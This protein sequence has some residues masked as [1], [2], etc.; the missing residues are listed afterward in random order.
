MIKHSACARGK[1]VLVILRDGKRLEGRFLERHGGFIWLEE[2]GKIA[3]E[4]VRTFSILK[5]GG[6]IRGRDHHRR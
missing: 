2:T 5:G 6:M 4:E 3:L 1:R